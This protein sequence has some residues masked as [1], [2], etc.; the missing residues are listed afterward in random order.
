M[1]YAR[2][3]DCTVLHALNDLATRV[4]DGTQKTV[5]TVNHF[6]DYCATHPEE[7]VLY[8][9]ASNMILYNYSDVAYLVATGARSRAV[10]YM[11]LGN[12]T[13]NKQIINGPISIIAKIIKGVMSSFASK[14]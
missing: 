5:E 14:K 11:Y 12:D 10:G 13:N 9:Q 3:V 7:V 6:L 2:V 1:Y 4:K 8:H